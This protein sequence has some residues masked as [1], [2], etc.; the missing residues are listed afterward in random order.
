MEILYFVSRDLVVSVS[1]MSDSFATPVD[2][3]PLL[4]SV[5][6]FPKQ[7]NWSE[8]PFPSPGDLP[9]PGIE[10]ASP[11]WQVDSLLSEPRGKPCVCITSSLF[12]RLFMDT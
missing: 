8:L 9:Y 1:V 2:C 11:A 4:S 5:H 6:G 10:L 7:E 12:I 3:S